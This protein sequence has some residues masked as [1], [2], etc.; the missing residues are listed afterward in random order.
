M[1]SIMSSVPDLPDPE[2]LFA[3]VFLVLLEHPEP[4]E[5]Q[6]FLVD[7]VDLVDLLDQ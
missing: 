1:K 3:Q 7:L 5:D 6:I 4:H 2:D